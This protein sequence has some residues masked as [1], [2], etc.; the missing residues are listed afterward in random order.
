MSSWLAPFNCRD[1]VRILPIVLSIIWRNLNACMEEPWRAKL[2]LWILLVFLFNFILIYKFV[3]V[4]HT[5]SVFYQIFYNLATT[6]KHLYTILDHCQLDHWLLLCID[7]SL[8]LK[9]VLVIFAVLLYTTYTSVLRIINLKLKQGLIKST[10]T[11]HYIITQW[12]DSYIGMHAV[13][14]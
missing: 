6:G 13:N 9:P 5:A 8:T 10:E 2:G 1:F 11:R 12:E 7:L 14:C 4:H 3:Y